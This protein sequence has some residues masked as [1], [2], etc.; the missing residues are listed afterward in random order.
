MIAFV[1]L[2]QIYK[3]FKIAIENDEY[4][5][6]AGKNI[7]IF[8]IGEKTCDGKQFLEAVITGVL[9]EK[10]PLEFRQTLA[11]TLLS[12]A[13]SPGFPAND[14]FSSDASYQ[15]TVT[16]K[17]LV[18]EIL[19]S[20][21]PKDSRSQLESTKKELADTQEALKQKEKELRQKEAELAE[22][23][24]RVKNLQDL[25]KKARIRHPYAETPGKHENPFAVLGIPPT[26][27]EAEIKKAWKQLS[28]LYHPDLVWGLFEKGKVTEDPKAYA[29]RILAQEKLKEINDAYD[30]LK[31]QGK[32]H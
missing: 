20:G 28:N 29:L 10:L 12:M 14:V 26:A 31:L 11:G 5:T 19:G 16:I 23:K 8:K 30:D 18:P 27:T 7:D 1:E 13:S 4:R 9:D 6:L 17:A 21:S 15:K 25:L 2:H 24:K 3:N 32:V 22:E